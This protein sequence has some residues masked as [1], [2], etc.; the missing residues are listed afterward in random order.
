MIRKLYWLLITFIITVNIIAFIHAYKFT[1][2][3]ATKHERTA[4]P[5]ELSPLVKTKV[6]FTGI[7]NPKPTRKSLPNLTFKTVS[8][9]SDV[10]LEAWHVTSET[11][12]GTVILFHGYS[13]EKS[14]LISRAEEFT[15][16]GFN[17]LLVDFMG[18]GGSEGEGTTIGYTESREVKDAFEYIKQLGETNIHLFGTSMG[19]ATILKAI[20]DYRLP[21]SSLILECP[22]GSLY[23]TVCARF[24]LMGLPSFPMAGVLTFWGGFQQGYWAFGHNPSEYAKSVKCPTLLL[25]GEKDDRV[26]MEETQ[27]IYNNLQGKKVLVTYPEEGHNI[28][29]PEN[30]NS[31]VRDVAAFLDEVPAPSPLPLQEVYS[32]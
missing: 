22:F 12:K 2:F 23:E 24:N 1:H 26:S 8:I 20:E 27:D 4:D 30:T 15:K 7:D 3:S 28:F 10:M 11:S 16:L 29:T 17:T 14:S 5:K 25:Y 19:A 32:R 21:V 6:L 18:S 31:W 9:K 13:G